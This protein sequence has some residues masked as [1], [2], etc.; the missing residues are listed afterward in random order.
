MATINRYAMSMPF[1]S[2]SL[3]SSPCS[4]SKT[5]SYSRA[6]SR[7]KSVFVS[8]A[9]I[10]APT[11]IQNEDLVIVG[12][13][14]AGL[15][16]AVSLHR[17][18]I[19]SLVLEQAD[20]LRTGGTS[21]TLFKNGWRVLDTIGVADELRSQFLEIQGM[22]IKTEKGRELRSFK[23]KEVDK[24]QEVRAVE[25]SILLTTLADQLPPNTI[26][27]SSKLASIDSS[28]A[29][30][31]LLE[32]A[33]G[34]R[35]S[36]KIVIGCDGVRSTIAK[37]M[38]FA[39]PNYVG[40]YAFRGLAFYPKGQKYE[41]RVNYIYGDGVRGGY[42]PVSSTKVYWFIVYNCNSPGPRV[43]D[44]FQLMKQ[45]KE[46]VKGWPSDL[47]DIIDNTPERENTIIRS[48]LVDRWLWPGISPPPAPRGSNIVLAG[49]AWHPMTPNLGQGGCCA[50]ED[51]VVL[52]KKL[53][54]AMKSGEE[55]NIGEALGSY[56]KER[57]SR[58][59]PLTIRA[60]LVGKLLQW[61]NPVVCY[62]RNEFIV[63]KLVQIGPL[64][65]HTNF[66]SELVL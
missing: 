23:F 64:L 30:E 45:A 19:K 54:V 9:A 29:G 10:N 31:T 56:G 49:D 15:A 57:W 12:G 55:S 51:A 53:S 11:A 59:F 6:L 4:Q 25:R 17:L 7:S 66:D 43:T 62:I 8:R 18:G 38:G 60:N 20:S 36:A 2:F 24:S 26:K 52:A 39:E 40:H 13:G 48:P 32:L 65:E 50:L 14:I 33:N 28:D 5:C 46:L 41:P 22:V 44:P 61:D 16:T 3:S 37:W 27:F 21:L 1:P 42:V 35:I 63:P 47:Q 58:V 34:T